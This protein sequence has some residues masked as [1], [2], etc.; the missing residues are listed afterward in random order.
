MEIIITTTS[1][2]MLI[3][4]FAIISRTQPAEDNQGT[5]GEIRNDLAA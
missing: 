3:I 5:A 2:A 1:I 4:G